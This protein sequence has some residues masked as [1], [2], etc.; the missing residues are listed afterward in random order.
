VVFHIDEKKGGKP[1]EV[2]LHGPG[3][4]WTPVSRLNINF[5][6]NDGAIF[7]D[8]QGLEFPW[9]TPGY[10]WC[11]LACLGEENQRV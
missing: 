6:S 3:A 1:R 8:L 5:P 11:L 4:V 7:L 9:L 2:V 10:V